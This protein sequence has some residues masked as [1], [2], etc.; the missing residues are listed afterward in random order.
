VAVVIITRDRAPE[1]LRSLARLHELAERPEIVVVD[2]GSRDHTAELVGERFPRTRVLRLETNRGAAGRT[3]GV[4]AVDA[5]YVA[6]CD[7]DSWWAPGALARGAAILDAHPGVG[8]VAGRVLLG[9]E[10]RLEPA[11]AEMED[12]P[13]RVEPGM[14]GPRVLGFVACGAIVRRRAFLAVG[15]FDPRFGVGCEE[16]LLAADLAARGWS[17]VYCRDVVAHHHPSRVRERFKRRAAQVRNDLWFSWL[18]RAPRAAVGATL[19]TA[20][21]ALRD[22]AA[23][24]GLRAA[25]GGGAGVLAS[26]RRLPAGVE[27]DFRL[28]DAQRVATAR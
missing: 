15:G 9:G 11:C 6:F 1:L 14:P 10:E 24:A 22:P 21:A 19:A 4:R 7:D 20:S 2:N 3:V 18:R 12:S 23:R 16:R 8:V 5:P 25:A 17:L 27:A 28:L 26:R 13:L